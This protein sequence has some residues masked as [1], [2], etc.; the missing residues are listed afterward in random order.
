MGFRIRESLLLNLR[1]VPGSRVKARETMV[2]VTM[3]EWFPLKVP[4]AHGMVWV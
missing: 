4:S 3:G 2:S 1:K